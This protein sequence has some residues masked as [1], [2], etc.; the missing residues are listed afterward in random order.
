MIGSIS[1]YIKN[2][3]QYQLFSQ[4]DR[5]IDSPRMR[6]SYCVSQFQIIQDAQSISLMDTRRLRHSL[7]LQSQS[8]YI[9]SIIYR[10]PVLIIL[11]T[12]NIIYITTYISGYIYMNE[13]S[14]LPYDSRNLSASLTATNSIPVPI[15]QT[16]A[17]ISC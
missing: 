1:S 14:H 5:T 8:S 11:I 2:S 12:I 3:Y 4:R 16:K 6:K 15:S 13:S 9:N 10:S 7:T 17:A